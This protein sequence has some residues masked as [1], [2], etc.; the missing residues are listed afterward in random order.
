MK[1][2]FLCLLLPVCISCMSHSGGQENNE[3]RES[4]VGDSS[5]MISQYTDGSGDSQDAG[6][7]I[8][9]PEGKTILTRF[10]PP[11]GY[12][13]AP[14]DSG[15]FG[16]YLRDLPLKPDGSVVRLYDGREKPRWDVY[17]AVVDKAIGTRDLHQCADAV[18]RLRA[19]YFY[20]RHAF[21]KIRF[22]LTNG[23][24]FDFLDY[25]S[26][27]RPVF[28]GNRFSW[29]QRAEPDSGA[30]TYWKYLEELFTY[31]GT[32]SL[33]RE[34]VSVPD[35]DVRIGD[36]YIQGGSPGH[37]I[38]VVDQA[39]HP[40]TGEKLVMLA[41]SYM[42]AQ[43]IQ[44]LKNFQEPNLLC[45]FRIQPGETLYTPEWD[46]PAGSLKRFPE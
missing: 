46:F 33:S 12:V 5:G 6:Q 36:V 3:T 30:G 17:V 10:L 7:K 31:A 26:G 19:D 43:E 2:R 29:Q 45:W 38:L 20:S 1:R 25:A 37:A 11:A 40:Q 15:S 35:Q 16:A 28:S 39:I 41:Q 21:G 27:M 22:H 34:L 13:R 4:P 32:L 24:E 44:I 14:E 8:L 18:I 42:P 23:Q 9:V